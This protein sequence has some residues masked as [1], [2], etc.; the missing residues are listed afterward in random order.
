MFFSKLFTNSWGDPFIL[1]QIHNYHNEYSSKGA[2]DL[3]IKEVPKMFITKENTNGRAINREGY[4]I[5]PLFH[6]AP[7]LFGGEE[8]L[9]IA[10]ASWQGIFPA[11]AYR[12]NHSGLIIHLAGTGDHT[13]FR[14]RFGFANDLLKH[15]I[16]SILLEN[17]YYGSRKPKNQFRSSLLNVS[18]LFV[19]GGSLITE[20][21]FILQWAKSNGYFPLGISGVSMGGHMASLAITNVRNDQQICTIPC[22]SWTSGAPVY[23][24][25]ALSGAIPW[26]ILQ[27]K[28]ENDESL[29]K[30]I[31]TC[32]WDSQMEQGLALE[33]F[34]ESS[35]KRLMWSLMAEFT[36]LAKYPIPLNTSLIKSVVAED[37]AYVPMLD[38]IPGFTELWPG[39][40]VKIIKKKGHIGAYLNNHSLFRE[41]I[42]ECLS[43]V[44]ITSG[45]GALNCHP[46]NLIA[47]PCPN[48]RTKI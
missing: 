12:Q 47:N 43:Q 37:D 36:D 16:T 1:K 34:P 28:L 29:K 10:R 7:E 26:E 46:Q 41:T 32:G 11:D 20:C 18:D 3:L 19:M 14:R 2:V 22:L 23:T 48:G 24:I 31:R 30:T 39:S 45:L 6:L 42:L 13:F 9:N 40:E 38:R 21:F 17:P 5:S 25:G 8:N 33:L 35:A 27:N 15:G 4:F 44:L